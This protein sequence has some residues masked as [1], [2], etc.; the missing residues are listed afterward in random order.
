M[1]SGPLIAAKRSMPFGRILVPVD[2]SERSAPSLRIALTLAEQLGAEVI[3]VHVAAAK[4]AVPA[5]KLDE[6]SK[7]VG[8]SDVT[9]RR[10]ILVG[11][12]A[13]AITAFAEREGCDLVIL[14]TRPRTTLADYLLG[15]V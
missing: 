13:T 8:K 3:V 15:S 7:A 5:D 14:G 10:E 9:F 11:D 6:L 2:F 12:P 4:D 1:G